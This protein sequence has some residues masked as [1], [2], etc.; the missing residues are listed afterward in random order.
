MILS[1]K[2]VEGAREFVEEAEGSPAL[3]AARRLVERLVSSL[4]SCERAVH[5]AVFAAFD[6]LSHWIDLS[7]LSRPF[8][9]AK[10]PPFEPSPREILVIKLGALGDFVQAL[11]A[12][13]A[14]RRHHAR[15]RIT[16]LTTAPYAELA[17][18]S[19]LFDRILLDRRPRPWAF[20]DWLRLRRMLAGGRFE[21]VYD[22][23]TSDRSS[24]YLQL[25]GKPQWSGIAWRSSH[26]HANLDRDRQHTLDRQAEQLLMA[27]IYPVA[28]WPSLS[29]DAPLP[30]GLEGRPF[31]L[32][33]P[34]SAP[35]RP[36][37]R[38]P[39]DR[40]AALARLL[41]KAGLP[42][43][44]VG[45][46]G[47]KE[48]AEE[49]RRHAPEAKDLVGRTDIV[50]LAALARRAAVAIGNDTGATH[51]AAASATP[52]VVLFS[53][54]SDPDLCAPRGPMV[55]VLREG[56]LSLLPVERVFAEARAL[57]GMALTPA[58]GSGLG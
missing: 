22:L 6:E 30:E 32:L 45:L 40:Y 46:A 34:G 49:I 20:P 39:A 13:A 53:A 35:H 4:G 48:I 51:L 56:D 33:I 19:G 9:R 10:F 52:V 7:S 28:P 11:A 31:A 14:I 16:L 2:A 27:G 24:F 54:A 47:E 5:A 42:P 41:E 17:S 29:L 21:R 3:A 58:G 44:I 50:S 12:A 38:W 26:P 25:M 55:R 15:E 8:P 37:K 1:E 18:A 23:Q 57:S 36:R 43:V